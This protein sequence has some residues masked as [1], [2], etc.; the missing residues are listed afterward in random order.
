[1]RVVR[2]LFAIATRANTVRVGIGVG[3][4]TSA[5]AAPVGLFDLWFGV[6]ASVGLTVVMGAVTVVGEGVETCA[7]AATVG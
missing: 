7:G 6:G 3:F 1:M 2:R 5:D 4:A